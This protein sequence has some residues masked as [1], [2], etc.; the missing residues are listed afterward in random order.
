[1]KVPENFEL[2]D[3]DFTSYLGAQAWALLKA[4][5]ELKRLRDFIK[6]IPEPVA[7]EP[8]DENKES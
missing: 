1:M 8:A 3:A 7:D 6:A 2:E 4:H 5:A